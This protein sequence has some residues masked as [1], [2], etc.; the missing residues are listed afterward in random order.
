M[1]PIQYFISIAG[2]AY[3]ISLV[4]TQSVITIYTAKKVELQS[5]LTTIS[6]IIGAVSG[7]IVFLFFAKVEISFLVIAFM[8]NDI[9][10]GYILGKK[11]FVSYSKYFLLQ[12]S[13]TF[14]LGILFYFIFGPEGIIFGIVLSYVHFIIINFVFFLC[15]IFCYCKIPYLYNF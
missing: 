1:H 6:L 12:K 13:F 9:G 10:L 11:F 7:G 14:L 4:G 5:T 2:L 15:I 8:L 3:T